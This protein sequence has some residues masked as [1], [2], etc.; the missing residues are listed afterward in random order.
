[1]PFSRSVAA[2]VMQKHCAGAAGRAVGKPLRRSSAL[3]LHLTVSR[4]ASQSRVSGSERPDAVVVVLG[5]CAQKYYNPP[6]YS[7]TTARFASAL[8]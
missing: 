3:L 6:Y 4:A 5:F 1:M 2:R 8:A 7:Y